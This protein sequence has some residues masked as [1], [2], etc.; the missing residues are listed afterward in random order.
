MPR[1]RDL[2][3]RFRPAGA[4]GAA[5]A[6]GVPVDRAAD[7]TAEL[8]P[9]FARL[10]DTERACA[11]ILAAARRDAET[12][13]EDGLRRAAAIETEALRRRDAERA[14][15]AARIRQGNDDE[16]A[17]LLAEADERANHIR[18]WGA[19]QLPR[20][21]DDAVTAVRTL[22]ADIGTATDTDSAGGTD[23]AAG[24]RARARAGA[25]AHDRAGR[26][27]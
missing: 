1:V 27:A 21:R 7:A 18:Q 25:G 10:T 11:D 6:A 26:G 2:L 24:S 19:S 13:R 16:T 8:A 5:T 3:F 4:P 15:A 20:Y 22:I 9:L 14:A 23:S 17:T 12:Q